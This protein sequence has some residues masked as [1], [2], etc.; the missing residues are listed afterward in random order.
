[1]LAKRTYKNQITIPKT[2][3]A[4]FP[5]IEY[6]DVSQR[7]NAIVLRPVDTRPAGARLA[8]IRAKVKTLGLTEADIDA[9]IRWA[10]K[11]RV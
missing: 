9:A 8:K 6:F 1:M 10:R 2:V 11:G 7:H 5:D 3:M 4:S